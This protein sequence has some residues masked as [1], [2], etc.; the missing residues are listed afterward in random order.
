MTEA[1]P[2]VRPD[3][4]GATAGALL[5]ATAQVLVGAVALGAAGAVVLL[6]VVSRTGGAPVEHPRAAYWLSLVAVATAAVDAVHRAVRRGPWAA[7]A[8]LGATAALTAVA[9]G[10]RRS[11]D[12]AD[13]VAPAPMALAGAA[14]LAALVG[15]AVGLGPGARRR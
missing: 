9:V 13:P 5:V 11:G 12:F 4:A 8:A 15:T 2:A 7:T 10:L 14:L 1:P 3:P 6:D